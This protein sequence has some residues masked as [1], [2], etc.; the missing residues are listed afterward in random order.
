MIKKNI[1]L[2]RGGTLEVDVTPQFLEI[3]QKHFQLSNL[4]LVDDEH[5]RMYIWGAFKN[6][7]D[8]AEKMD[9]VYAGA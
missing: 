8:K 6:A 9:D 7:I 1:A 2:P 4:S 5:I 3:V